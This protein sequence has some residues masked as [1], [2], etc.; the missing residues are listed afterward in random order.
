MQSTWSVSSETWGTAHVWANETYQRD[1]TVSTTHNY[2]NGNNALY[3]ATADLAQILFSELH[4]EDRVSLLSGTLA[5]ALGVSTSCVL[6]LPVSGSIQMIST[7]TDSGSLQ[8]S[9]LATLSSSQSTSSTNNTVFPA[10]A[11]FSSVLDNLDDEDKVTLISAALESNYGIISESVLKAVGSISLDSTTGFVNNIN[12]PETATIATDVSTS[13]A[14]NF[15]W[16]TETESSDTWSIS[17]EET[18]TWT[19]Q[20]EDDTTWT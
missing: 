12:Y 2:N 7:A 15:L 19:T 3:P 20:P 6:V 10:T 13:S 11:T 8:T 1:C 16:N 18:T 17:T 4:E 14:S 5:S 9:G